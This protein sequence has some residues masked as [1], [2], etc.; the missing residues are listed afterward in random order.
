MQQ[1][2]VRGRRGEDDAELVSNDVRRWKVE[3]RHSA[4]RLLRLVVLVLVSSP[5]SSQAE[6]QSQTR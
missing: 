1:Q 2:R 3:R 6:S 5:C 4:S